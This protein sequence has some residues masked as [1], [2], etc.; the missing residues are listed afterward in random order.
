MPLLF[1]GFLCAVFACESVA[2]ASARPT[3][4]IMV[5]REREREAASH[6]SG[7]ACRSSNIK[8]WTGKPSLC[9]IALFK[10]FQLC[11]PHLDQVFMTA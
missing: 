4:A 5:S 1:F 6:Q 9:V 11:A 2:E 7:L 8:E 10:I 3:D